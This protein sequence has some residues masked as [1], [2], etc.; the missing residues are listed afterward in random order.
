MSIHDDHLERTPVNHLPLSPISF[1]ERSALAYPDKTAVIDGDRRLDYRSLFS[2]CLSFA[3]ALRRRGVGRGDIV[4][5]LSS[6]SLGM[7]EAHYGVP[8]AG[9]VLN[10]INFR[11]DPATIAYILEHCEARMLMAS[12]EFIGL[13][14]EALNRMNR[15]IALVALDGDAGDSRWLSY[16]DFLAEGSDAGRVALPA[17][18]WD[19]I[20]LCYTSGTTGKPKGVVYH[21]RGAA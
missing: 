9:A 13:A 12:R 20:S 7:L 18:E 16:E 19:A 2:R 21:H 4:S 6:N 5:L 11:L 15:P 3:D 8:M 14:E 1:L 10:T 17:D